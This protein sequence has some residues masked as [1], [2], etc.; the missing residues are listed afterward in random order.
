MIDF[1]TIKGGGRLS[2]CIGMSL[3]LLEE[4][5]VKY[6][7]IEIDLYNMEN[8]SNEFLNINPNGKVPC[9]KDDDF[10]IWESVAINYYLAS[11]Y[12]SSLMG[13]NIAQTG[14]VYQWTQWAMS[15]L[16][17]AILSIFKNALAPSKNKDLEDVRNSKYKIINCT[18]VLNEYLKG[19]NFILGNN[20]SVADINLA[21]LFSI[22]NILHTDLNSFPDFNKWLK[23][24]L[25]SESLQKLIDKKLII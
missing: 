7:V 9:I 19:K 17:P 25:K 5:S 10:I 16:Q 13:R 22:H 6:N 8:K 23:L 21:A 14:L 3:W 15:E 11:K 18:F 24:C 12:K 20:F 4:L 2:S 1:Y